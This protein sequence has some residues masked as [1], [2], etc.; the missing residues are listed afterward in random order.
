[1]SHDGNWTELDGWMVMTTADWMHVIYKAL[2]ITNSLE[3]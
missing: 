2:G 1:M 3:D